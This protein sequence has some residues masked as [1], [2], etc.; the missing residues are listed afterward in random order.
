M[1]TYASILSVV[2]LITGFTVNGC[3][4]KTPS[5]S[6]EEPSDTTV[7]SAVETYEKSLTDVKEDFASTEI[8]EPAEE[9]ES[10]VEEE[11]KKV[12]E[13]VPKLP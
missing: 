6:P 9:L 7:P 1:K 11:T 4:T 8:K 10:A 5:P 2:I 12:K 3:K 13:T